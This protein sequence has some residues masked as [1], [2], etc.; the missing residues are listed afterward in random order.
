MLTF[1]FRAA[2]TRMLLS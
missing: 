1:R 2:T